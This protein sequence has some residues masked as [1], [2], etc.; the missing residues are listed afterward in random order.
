MTS[1][2][3]R[4]MQNPVFTRIYQDL[5]RPAFTRLFSLGG[6]ATADFDTALRAYL[7]RPGERMVLDAA[8]GPGNYTREIADHLD[9][10]GR[11]V[12]IDFAAA[13]L[14]TAAR[15]NSTA[16]TCYIR[17]DAHHLPFPDDTFDETIC[18]AALYLIPDP[19]PVVDELVRVTKPGGQIILFASVRTALTSLPG[20][21][22]AANLVGYRIYD[23]HE[24]V[25]RLSDAGAVDV[26]QTI[27]GMGQYVLAV[28]P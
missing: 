9:G 5:W 27:T 23:E 11:C 13:M 6:H 22:T 2:S 21:D 18:L 3:Q 19:L 20:A 17:T 14:A 10:D 15:R 12:G 25:D 1:L 16:R 7:T 8:C 26:E 24:L 4:V 28:K